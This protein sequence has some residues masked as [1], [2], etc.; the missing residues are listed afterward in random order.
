MRLLFYFIFCLLPIFYNTENKNKSLNMNKN[1]TETTILNTLDSSIEGDY[2]DFIDLGHGYFE[3]ANCRL[4]LFKDENKWAIVFEKIGYNARAGEPVQFVISYFGNCLI[5]LPEYNGQTS[6]YD[7]IDVENDIYKVLNSNFDLI[8][9]RGN[10]IHI[11]MDKKAYSDLGIK[12]DYEGN[13]YE[14][15]VLKY[16]AEKYPEVTRASDEELKRCIPAGLKKI[17]IIDNWFQEEYHQFAPTIPPSKQEAFQMIA[18]VLVTGETKYYNPTK[19]SNTHW[20][21]WPE[22]GGL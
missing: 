8:S 12:W 1:L 13:N 14:G 15:A 4:T 7:I 9:I 22:S 5:N 3:L 10:K 6:N 17:M 20:S 2:N 19:K 16:L 21:Y 11:P 18:K